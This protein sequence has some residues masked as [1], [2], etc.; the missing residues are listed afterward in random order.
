MHIHTHIDL[1]H[2]GQKVQLNINISQGKSMNPSV[3]HSLHGAEL[4]PQTQGQR[5]DPSNET[6][7]VGCYR[8]IFYLTTITFHSCC[9]AVVCMGSWLRW[10]C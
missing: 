6:N 10:L 1:S 9:Y 8:F 5:S 4:H 7:K 3:M 2:F